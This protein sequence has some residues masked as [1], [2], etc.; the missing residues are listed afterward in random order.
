MAGGAV[1]LKI[2]FI[3]NGT[4]EQNRYNQICVET[5]VNCADL[6]A[7]ATVF[8]PVGFRAL[9][10]RLLSALCDSR[11]NPTQGFNTDGTLPGA[12]FLNGC[13]EDVFKAL[14]AAL[15]QLEITHG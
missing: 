7:L 1:S 12:I 5:K 15:L 11:G 4:D 14:D 8:S 6:S 10:G 3:S 13:L 2:G 9:G